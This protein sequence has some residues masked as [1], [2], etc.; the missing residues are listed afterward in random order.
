ML[1]N[2]SANRPSNNWALIYNYYPLSQSKLLE[3]I[4]FIAAHTYIAHIWQ[5]PPGTTSSL[6]YFLRDSRA[7]E[8]RA[9]V[10]IP[11]REKRQ[12]AGKSFF[13]PRG[14]IFTRARVSLPLLSLRKNGG[15]L[16]RSLSSR[17]LG[18]TLSL[19]AL[20]DIYVGCLLFHRRITSHFFPL[21][22]SRYRPRGKGKTGR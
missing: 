12:H 7:S 3:N 22:P 21:S 14:V 8:T 9:R 15:L 6:S 16:A 5:Y 1:L 13:P 20:R 4:P 2:T 10:K 18:S 11:P 19:R 17:S